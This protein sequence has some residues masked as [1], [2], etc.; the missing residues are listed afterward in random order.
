MTPPSQDLIQEESDI[1]VESEVDPASWPTQLYENEINLQQQS[2]F[3][4]FLFNQ[5]ENVYQP[6]TAIVSRV[7]ENENGLLAVIKHL[8]KYP[9]IKEILIYNQLNRPLVEKFPNNIQ[10][11][12]ANLQS[13]GKFTACAVAS[14]SKCYFQ[15][16][17]WLN[18]YMD[19][20]YTHSLRYPQLVISNI[21]QS[22]YVDYNTWRFTHP[23]IDF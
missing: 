11:I 3:P 12:D 18:P 4:P 20:L 8:S 6:V 7:D 16:D 13:M 15:D 1:S 2:I 9:F 14:Y 23:N 5:N 17:L 19:S 10:I 21:R 22:N